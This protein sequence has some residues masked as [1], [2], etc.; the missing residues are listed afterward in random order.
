MNIRI[1][2]II[3]IL[4]F[5]FSSG[6]I[7]S[8]SIK[9]VDFVNPFM[10]TSNSRWELN[11]G[12]LL[13]F[14]MMQMAPDNQESFW[15][16][17]YEYTI[18]SISGFSVIHNATMK[19]FGIMPQVGYRV[20][21][22]SSADGPFAGWIWGH[23][24]RFRKETEKASAGY[25]GVHLMDYDVKVEITSTMRSNV[26]RL[27]YPESKES[28]LLF[29]LSIPSEIASYLI[30]GKAKKVSDT[31]IEGY[32]HLNTSPDQKG[33]NDYVLYFV[34][35]LSKPFKTFDGWSQEKE[36]QGWSPVDGWKSNGFKENIDSISGKNRLGCLLNFETTKGE[37]INLYTGISYVS[38]NQARLNL[39]TE[40]T[41]LD[42]DFNRVQQNA[43]DTWN[44]LLSKIEV[45]GG[46]ET[47]K[48]KFYT[49]LYRSYCGHSTF[50]DANGKYVDVCENVQ[51]IDPKSPILGGD[52]FWNTYWNLN[53]LWNLV[54]PEKSS[55][56]IRSLLEMY[57]KGGWLPDA[58][59]GVEYWN[60]MVGAHQ[61]ALMASAYH[62]GIRDYD[63]LQFYES[64]KHIMSTQGIQ[65]SCG[66]NAGIMDLGIYEKYGFIP[67]D[68]GIT[69]HTLDYAF[70][71]YVVSQ[72]AKAMGHKNDYDKF[73][74]RALNYRNVFHPGYKYVWEKRKDG[75]WEDNFKTLHTGEQFIEGNAWQYSFYVP[76]DIQGV[77]NIMGK[78]TFQTRLQKGFEIGAK[79]NFNATYD[80]M[81]DYPINQGNQ[82]NMQAAYLFNHG[83]APWLTQYW[84]REIMNNYY[85]SDPYKAWLG[86]EDEGQM[87]AWFVISAMGLFQMDG[88]TSV[89]PYYE[90]GSPIFDAIIVHLDDRYY[91]GKTFTIVTE[92]NSPENRFIDSATLNGKPLQQ[93]WFYCK[94]ATNGG[95]L[96]LVMSNKPNKN[97]G[98]LP[99]QA[100]PSMTKQ[101]E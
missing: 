93:A 48:I 100:P 83:G 77:V 73:S 89:K 61:I 43:R 70:D 85:G 39:E 82:V 38:C 36:W 99:E 65:H 53:T 46:T 31:E 76:H 71:D 27:T 74:K 22:Q 4:F 5:Q 49:N 7:Y 87:G 62:S 72:L 12:P 14:G 25:Y 101:V 24:S 45:K 19:G 13:P 17:G 98:N 95:T 9:P 20:I 8:Q 47:D 55:Q 94:E 57:K 15:K 59:V 32:L 2:K 80:L 66:G 92:N 23:R 79:T 3:A 64:I 56:W 60:V 50:S 69:S 63:T 18:N 96:K 78:D 28:R 58:P 52:S 33:F 75:T 86:D 84:V 10:G 81:S 54:S 68:I 21:S 1:S 40:L 90:I 44:N 51:Q 35:K 6:F 16:G 37:V 67:S 26:M 30:D 41:P 88:G 97:W 91:K 11:P 34:C 29:D 42:W